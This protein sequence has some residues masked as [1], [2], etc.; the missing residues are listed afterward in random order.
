M[1]QTDAVLVLRGLEELYPELRLIERLRQTIEQFSDIEDFG[2]MMSRGQIRSKLWLMHELVRANQTRLGRVMVCAG[3]YGLLARLLLDSEE[4]HVQRVVSFDIDSACVAPALTLNHPY[5]E[6]DMFVALVADL[7]E[8]NIPYWNVDTVINTSCEHVDVERWW[9]GSSP[10]P[11]Y[12]LQSN[13]FREGRDH[14][15]CV[16]SAD[17]LLEQA[18]MSEV[19]FKGSIQLIKYKRHMV[20]GRK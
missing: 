2:D 8:P 15:N 17:E 12:V 9:R 6:Q 10:E 1:A 16:D 20:I 4:L 14:I 3:W 5:G 18:P 19:L 7:Y 11:L 13:D